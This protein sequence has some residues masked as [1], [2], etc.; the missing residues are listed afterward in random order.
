MKQVTAADAN[1]NFSGLLRDVAA[2]ETVV[3]TSHGRPVATI[4]AFEVGVDEF[5]AEVKKLARQH[6]W[7]HL[8]SRRELAIGTMTRDE[9][10]E[11]FL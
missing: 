7:A 3:V 8:G 6:L 5:D 4:T 11:D 2:G 1:R 10:Y 9:I